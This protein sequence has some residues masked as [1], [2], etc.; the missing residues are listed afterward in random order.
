MLHQMETGAYTK[1]SMDCKSFLSI[2][3]YSSVLYRTLSKLQ[4]TA[5][6][7]SATANL[8]LSSVFK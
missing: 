6:K 2:P 4:L 5:T 7:Q 8:I 3:A 1:H